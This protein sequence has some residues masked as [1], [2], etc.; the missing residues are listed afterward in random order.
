MAEVSDSLAL[1][2]EVRA[3]YLNGLLALPERYAQVSLASCTAPWQGR[4]V[5]YADD[6]RARRREGK[7]LFLVGPPGVGKTTVAC[8]VARAAVD[9]SIAAHFTT[10]AGLIRKRIDLIRKEK[11]GEYDP[12]DWDYFDKLEGWFAFVVIDDVGKEHTTASGFAAHELDHL[13]RTR[14]SNMLPTIITTNL[15]R[16]EWEKA[17]GPSMASFIYEACYPIPITDGED[18]R[19]RPDAR[20]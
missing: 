11:A 18:F 10:L 6:L 2:R 19:L 9:Q 4:V 3:R 17:Y 13:L 5:R 1:T 8:A 15:T 20:K 12:A 14:Y 16:P 7:G